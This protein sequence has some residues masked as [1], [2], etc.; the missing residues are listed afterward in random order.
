[1]QLGTRVGWGVV[2]YA[3]LFLVTSTMAVYGWSGLVPSLAGLLVLL[4][5]CVW[6]GWQLKFHA[7]T[8]ILSYSIG[9]AIIALALDAVVAVP[10]QGW[11]LYSEWTAWAGYLLIVLLPLLSVPLRRRVANVHGPWES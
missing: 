5:V 7:W 3:I 2:I 10:D 6:A 8:D 4:I 11:G 9:W 1:M